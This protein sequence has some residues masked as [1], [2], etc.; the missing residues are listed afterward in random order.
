ML[1]TLAL[2]FAAAV[3][4]AVLLPGGIW[5][6]WAALTLLCLAVVVLI[7]RKRLQRRIANLP[8][9]LLLILCAAAVGLLYVR[10][11]QQVICQPVTQQCGDAHSF[12][13]TVCEQAIPT[14]S[15]GKV[16]VHLSGYFGAKAVYYGDESVLT[17]QPGQEISGT[18][19]WQDASVIHG[20]KVNTFTARGVYVLLYGHDAPTVVADHSRKISYWPQ[21]ASA[22]VQKKVTQIWSDSQTCGFTMAELTGDKSQMDS[23][24]IEVME[25]VGLAHLFAVSGLHCA[26]LVTLLGLLIPPR[27]RWL[28]AL[29]AAVVL[30]FYMMMVGCSPS[31]VRA[32]I[33]QLFLLAAPICRRDSD[34]LTSLSA[35]LFILLLCNPFAAAS[36]SL[37]LSFA[38][39]FGLI[40]VSGRLYR[41]MTAWY[42]GKNK[43]FRISL[44]FVAANISASL[45]ALVFTIPLTAY[46][47]DVF[48]LI[49]PLSNLLA[50]PVAGWNFIVGFVT[51]LLS[52]L[53]LPAAKILGWLCYGCVHDI[54]WVCGLLTR[55]PWH[56]LYTN[57]VMLKYWLLYCYTMFIGCAGTPDRRRKYAV[58][59]ALACVMLIC[60]VRLDT[61]QYRY[62]EMCAVAV[63][64]GQ[65]ESILLHSGEQT[66]LI[67]CGSSNRYVD[68]AKQVEMQ[69]STMNVSSLSALVV[70]HY[71]ADHTNGLSRLLRHIPVETMY[72][73]DIEDE[74]GVK[75]ELLTIAE[76]YGIIVV[77]VRELTEVPLGNAALTVYPPVGKGD[78]NEQGLSAMCKAGDFELL[79]TGDMAGSTEK[80]LM[81]QYDLPRVEVLMVSHH[82]SRYSS[83]RDFLKAIRPQTAVISVG[84]NSYGHPS[85]TAMARLLAAGADIYRTDL[86][87]NILITVSDMD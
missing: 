59:A 21:R 63:D 48:T 1:A 13:A 83:D 67:D 66:A 30:L 28:Y 84:D 7:F 5:S 2:S 82:G 40:T 55:L 27:R 15:G 76:K 54:L 22:A 44:A 42:Q 81:E 23:A 25:D 75:E 62:G 3:F 58:A 51:V 70:T 29:S 74:Y 85:D 47:F 37:Q 35:A 52:F 11:Y 45:G 19:Y 43:V 32:C 41:P 14:D 80:A 46:Y 26:F 50:V 20:R 18:A 16:T 57:N 34:G 12:S 79:T 87:G 24:D 68:A 31:V 53:S 61:R 8:R 78:L 39:T 73:P 71:H 65:G 86:G 9:R 49:S 38:A 60:V 17:L 64:V 6:F 72:L 36:V 69:L 77:F 33:M 56:A 4:G 10:G